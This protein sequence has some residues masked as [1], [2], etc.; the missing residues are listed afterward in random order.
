MSPRRP[1]GARALAGV[2]ALAFAAA[3][4]AGASDATRRG[5]SFGPP[6]SWAE[7]IA[8]DLRASP[9][10]SEISGGVHYLLVDQQ[11]R[12][13]PR[14]EERFGHFAKRIVNEAGLEAA[15]QLS[16]AYDPGYE[17]VELHFLRVRRGGAVL[18]R[19]VRER[20]ELVQRESELEAQVYDGALSAIAF[21]EDLRVGDVVE[22]AYTLRGANPVLGGRFTEGIDV[23]WSVPLRHLRYRL[24]WPRERTLLVRNHGTS[25]APVI[26]DA[27]PARQYVW[28][29]EE[30]APVA[31]PGPVPPWYARWAWVQLSEFARWADVAAWA[32]PLYTVPTVLP[33]DLTAKAEGWKRLPDESERARAALRFVQDEVRYVGIEM[34]TGSH[35]P[36]APG[37]VFARR[38]GDCKDKSLLLSTLLGA[39]GLRAR[40][41]L[42]HTS[43]G[44]GLDDW[45]PTPYAFNHV[46]TRAEVGG[47]VLWLDPT[48]T[49]QGGM[50]GRTCFPDYERAL[51][52]DEGVLD[53]TEIAPDIPARPTETV[54]EEY[55]VRDDGKP[56]E[57]SVET[58]YEGC[59]ADRAR[60][61][62]RRRSRDDV[63]KGYTDFYAQT[64]PGIRS[65]AAL[66]VQDDREKNVLLVRERYAIPGFWS[67][68]PSPGRRQSDLWAS[69]LDDELRRPKIAS[70]AP[71]AVAYPV[72]L[73]HVSR[74]RL[75]GDWGLE[76]DSLDLAT[77]AVRF[78]Y[79][80]R[81]AGDSLSLEYEYQTFADAVP[82]ASVEAHLARL[83]QMRGRLGYRLTRPAGGRLGGT[84]W[85]AVMT[86][87]LALALAG[88]GGVTLVR[89][90]PH[91]ARVA[92][93][94][95]PRVATVVLGALVAGAVV[96]HGAAFV[97][98][99]RLCRPASWAQRTLPDGTL[100]HA[101]WAPL[102]LS[103][104]VVAVLL[105]AAA[106]ALLVPLAR[107]RRASRFAFVAWA[108]VQ[109]G[110][111]FAAAAALAAL[112]GARASGLGPAAR[113]AFLSLVPLVPGTAMAL[114]RGRAPVS[115]G[116]SS[117]RP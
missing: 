63:A 117:S 78:S 5:L 60:A 24:L 13:S 19:L 40:P 12:V 21:I 108:F 85:V 29:L 105:L 61:D 115:A 15:S 67:D 114:A 87:A 47:R 7:P 50:L 1:L 36:T 35:R 116:A 97:R 99:W 44:R 4:P 45:L 83:D 38:F 10:A 30:E 43:R 56:V 23:E 109:T 53:L 51:V 112:P 26:D 14:G 94:M 37:V 3:A 90:V 59:D 22:Y 107:G 75:P 106:A 91:E 113:D 74:V 68:G 104:L 71:L 101:L 89:L 54:E 84:N 103:Q 110:L 32:R 96:V 6:P 49:A 64:W 17:T 33:P 93:P 62:L 39:L 69:T 52:V 9:P 42:V 81:P 48:R 8:V 57:Y 20:V 92:L 76:P 31:D 25:V 77:P 72:F 27:G 46:V 66:E 95:R 73:R 2:A 88:L 70:H 86:V 111:L 82:A 100:H 34:G 98:A 58:R 65:L 55:R 28:E 11:T 79:R 16:V 41:A 18:D 80:A 102:L